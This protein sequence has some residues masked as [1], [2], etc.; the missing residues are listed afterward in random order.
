M[1]VSVVYDQA[2]QPLLQ[3]F[4]DGRSCMHQP[5]CVHGW[6][7]ERGGSGASSAL[8]FD[9]PPP[10]SRGVLCCGYS[11]LPPLSPKKEKNGS[12]KKNNR[13][14]TC[15][16]LKMRSPRPL[17]AHTY[18]DAVQKSRV[19]LSSFSCVFCFSTLRR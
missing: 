16:L 11:L 17:R 19:S 9:D 6:G 10:P 15:S 13:Q 5:L 14:E 12:G 7:R 2:V 1:R 18:V 3:P 8:S 4:F